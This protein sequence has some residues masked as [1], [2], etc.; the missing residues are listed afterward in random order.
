M[1]QI[2]DGFFTDKYL[3]KSEFNRIVKEEA[4]RYYRTYI[5]KYTNSNSNSN[6]ISNQ[7]SSNQSNQISNNK[8]ISNINSE[9]IRERLIK[10]AKNIVKRDNSDIPDEPEANPLAEKL[11]KFLD[12]VVKSSLMGLH[13]AN[14]I[15]SELHLGRTWTYRDQPTGFCFSNESRQLFKA[16]KQKIPQYKKAL[17]IE[18]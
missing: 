13:T 7:L 15:S 10:K 9:H 3:D 1:I 2:Y 5:S 17:R 18:D 8:S 16:L 12:K 6:S 11:E 14:K 4:M